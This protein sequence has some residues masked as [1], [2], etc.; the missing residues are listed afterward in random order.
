MAVAGCGVTP[1]A[2]IMDDCAMSSTPSEATS[3]ASGAELRSGRYTTNS[4]SAPTTRTNS[5]ASGSAT[6]VGRAASLPAF[7]AQKA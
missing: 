5:R 7:S 2:R 6:A 3:L 4:V 1:N